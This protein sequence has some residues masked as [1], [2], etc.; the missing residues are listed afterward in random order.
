[1]PFQLKPKPNLLI[2]KGCSTCT[3]AVKWLT[4]QGVDFTVRD[5]FTDP[6]DTDHLRRILHGRPVRDLVSTRS[7]Q[8]KE[9]GLADKHL[10]DDEWL[11]LMAGNP[12]LIRRPTLVHEHGLIIGFDKAAYAELND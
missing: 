1:M 9:L 3:D 2:K 4:E 10:S 7:P 12:Y 6:L 8:Y 11:D 5:M